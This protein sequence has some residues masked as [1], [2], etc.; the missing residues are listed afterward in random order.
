MAAIIPTTVQT[1]GPKTRYETSTVIIH[2]KI[3]E[4]FIFKD[5]L[6]NVIK[7]IQR[8]INKQYIA[9][10]AFLNTGGELWA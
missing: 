3:D 5:P 9:C 1:T 2:S 4:S 8:H 6:C 10:K 7:I